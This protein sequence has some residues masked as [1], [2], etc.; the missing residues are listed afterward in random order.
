MPR[1]TKTARAYRGRSTRTGRCYSNERWCHLGAAEH[2]R[3]VLIN[4]LS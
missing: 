1:R 2:F 4:Y 3:D